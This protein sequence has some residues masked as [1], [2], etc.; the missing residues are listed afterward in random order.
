[1]SDDNIDSS[2]VEDEEDPAGGDCTGKYPVGVTM[3]VVT[4]QVSIQ[5]E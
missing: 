3:V 1:M 4:A 2:M 5:W